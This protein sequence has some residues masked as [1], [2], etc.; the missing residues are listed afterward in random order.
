MPAKQYLTHDEVRDLA[1]AVDSLGKGM[2]RDR[3]DT[4]GL[5]EKMLAYR[6]L[7]WG[8]ATGLRTSTSLGG[9]SKFG[10]PL[11]RSRECSSTPSRRTAMPALSPR[12]CR[13][14]PICNPIS[15]AGMA[16]HRLPQQPG[17]VGFAAEFVGTSLKYLRRSSIGLRRARRWLSRNDGAVSVAAC[18]P[19]PI[20][21]RL[22]A[23]PS[24]C[25]N[26]TPTFSSQATREKSPPDRRC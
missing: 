15:K 26:R 23:T 21:F 25:G 9:D 1:D 3:R 12:R 4:Y 10:T 14:T 2:Y 24:Y 19:T 13:S 8:R 18:L 11:S 5:L 20:G 22:A 6:G 7:R 16:A 17:V